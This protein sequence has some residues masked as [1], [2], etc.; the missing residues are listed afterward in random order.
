[1]DEAT[2]RSRVHELDT[3]RSL[4]SRSVVPRTGPIPCVAGHPRSQG[5]RAV[6]PYDGELPVDDD[7][8]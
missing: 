1:M 4:L 5:V 3:E 7:G 2:Y 6:N 8:G